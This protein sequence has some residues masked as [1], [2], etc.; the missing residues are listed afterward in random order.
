MFKNILDPQLVESVGGELG[1]EGMTVGYFI[2]QWEGASDI[3][4]LGLIA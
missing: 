4:K 1:F 2:N 3:T